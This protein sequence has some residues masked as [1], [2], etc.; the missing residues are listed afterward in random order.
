MEAGK[1][2]R[3]PLEPDDLGDD[4]PVEEVDDRGLERD[5]MDP[6]REVGPGPAP[7]CAGE[8]PGQDE[9]EERR[10][11][12][13]PQDGRDGESGVRRERTPPLLVVEDSDEERR[14]ER[15]EIRPGAPGRVPRY[16]TAAG[17]SRGGAFARA[18]RRAIRSATGGW[19]EKSWEA[20]SSKLLI[21]FTM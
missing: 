1:G 11:E 3:G 20:R 4:G 6:E 15:E 10:R 13:A 19:V 2:G 21:G 8:P 18:R 9:P 12:D 5:R 14:Q 16:S 17:N 7:P